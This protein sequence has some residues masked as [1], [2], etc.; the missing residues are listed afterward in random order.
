MSLLTN[1]HALALR[2]GNPRLLLT[3]NEYVALACGEL[4][5]DGILDV[6]DIETT[7]MT[8]TVSD[9]ANATH[10]ATTSS[11]GN[12]TSVKAYGIGD[13]A[14]GKVDLD[15]VVDLDGGIRVANA[16]RCVNTFC[17]SDIIS[18][19]SSRTW[20]GSCAPATVEAPC[21]TILSQVPATV[22]LQARRPTTKTWP[23]G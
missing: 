14:G 18:S 5:V 11:H 16:M 6:Y 3:N 8:F 12:D 15:S 17:S 10:V 7:V 22:I 1:L 21:T 19:K 20:A 2:Q 9:D 4:V 13:F 23:N